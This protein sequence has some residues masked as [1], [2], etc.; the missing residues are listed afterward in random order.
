MLP[1]E[2]RDSLRLNHEP[3]CQ[4]LTRVNHNYLGVINQSQFWQLVNYKTT[5]KGFYHQG[6]RNQHLLAKRT[7]PP[8]PRRRAVDVFCSS[9]LSWYWGCLQRSSAALRGWVGCRMYGW[10]LPRRW[11][12][13][14]VEVGS[15]KGLSSY[16]TTETARALRASTALRPIQPV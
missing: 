1:W 5:V 14:E 12:Q 11:C 15:T 7:L 16:N 10:L 2:Q 9:R 8:A 4:I 13:S 6:V 3:S